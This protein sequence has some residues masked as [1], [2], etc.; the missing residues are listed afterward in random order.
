MNGLGYLLAE[1]LR[2]S[3]SRAPRG[4]HKQTYSLNHWAY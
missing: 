2:P 3:V 1:R 4:K